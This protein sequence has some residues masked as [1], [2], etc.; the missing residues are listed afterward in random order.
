LFCA[1]WLPLHTLLAPPVLAHGSDVMG[2]AGGR[3][4]VWAKERIFSALL[5]R[6]G[7]QAVHQLLNGGARGAD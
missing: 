3:G 5:K 4:L 1:A 2:A 7:G 6:S